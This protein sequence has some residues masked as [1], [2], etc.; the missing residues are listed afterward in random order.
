M[1]QRILQ[2][3]ERRQRDEFFPIERRSDHQVEEIPTEPESW[4]EMERRLA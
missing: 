1:D 2:P 4:I 3:T